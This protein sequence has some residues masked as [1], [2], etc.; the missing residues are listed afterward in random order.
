MYI[1]GKVSREEMAQFRKECMI[2]GWT[3][4]EQ[5]GDSLIYL[6]DKGERHE[7]N[8]GA[9]TSYVVFS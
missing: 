5:R 8:V 4:L 7:L 2:L 6:D 3:I 1:E 9:D